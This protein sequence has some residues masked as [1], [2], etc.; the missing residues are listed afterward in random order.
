MLSHEQ[1]ELADWLRTLGCDA[2]GTWTFGPKWPSGPSPVSVERHVK[3]W[4]SAWRLAP[5]FMVV[6]AG[7]A[8]TGRY[9]AHGLLTTRGQRRVALWADWWRRYGRCE[10][11]PLVPDDDD[12]LQL[13]VTKYCCKRT[14][15]GHVL[16]M[17]WWVTQDGRW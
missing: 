9:H 1:R 3:A 5:A 4:I 7:T 10:F 16:P 17:R 14:M 15:D 13:Y 11:R 12:G 8:G 6:E 2:W